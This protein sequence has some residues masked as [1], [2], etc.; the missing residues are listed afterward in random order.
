MQFV[1]LA[2]V[3]S[4]NC[5]DMTK[6]SQ[7]RSVAILQGLTKSQLDKALDA[8]LDEDTPVE[9]LC[10][11]LKNV[12]KP[13]ISKGA[14]MDQMY[15]RCILPAETPNENAAEL[16]RLCRAAYPSVSET[17]CHDAAL[18]F[19]VKNLN[20]MELRRSLLLQPP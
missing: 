6:K 9:E 3:F 2:V 19:F 17:D 13:K 8:G 14:A 4:S 10:R 20:P 11:Q 7:D 16:R 15:T 5:P 18:H 1:L 12:L